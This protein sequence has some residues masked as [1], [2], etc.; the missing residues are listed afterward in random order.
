[1]N[2]PSNKHPIEDL[3]AVMA[4][5]RNPDGGCPW[6]LQQ[7]FKTIAPYTIEEAYEVADAIERNNM[8][9]L[10]EELG[11]L[12]LQPIYHAQMA[13]E[14]NLFTI[15]DVIRD[16]TEKMIS[17]HP[18]VFGDHDAQTPEDVNKI[19]DE[20][21]KAE[22]SDQNASALD[23]VTKALPALLRAKKLQKKAAKVGFEWPG[24][25]QVLDKLEEELGEMREALASGTLE[26]KTDELGDLLFVLANLARMLD[27][28]PE[29]A[30]R[31]CNDKFE[32]RFR[33]LEKELKQKSIDLKDASLKQM[34][35]EWVKQKQKEHR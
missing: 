15:E 6:D 35:Q 18:H 5:L 3:I 12:L 20:R 19:W 32:R 13:A 26:Q 34:E 1:M 29:T 17:R 2:K 27:I 33:G 14:D 31:E 22:K 28:N 9:D 7:N 25:A 16:I 23:G 24:P 11:D 10:R 21:K 30:L 8:N 4:A